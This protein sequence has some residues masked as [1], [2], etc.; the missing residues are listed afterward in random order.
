M[1]SGKTIQT[2]RNLKNKSQ[3]E[4]ADRLCIT[5]QAYSKLEQ[6]DSIDSKRLESILSALKSSRREL[7]SVK[8]FLSP[9]E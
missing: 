8:K 4:V 6:Q 3:R 5:Q 7:E 1:C 9:P 2:L